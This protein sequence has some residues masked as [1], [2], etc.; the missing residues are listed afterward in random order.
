ML[1]LFSIIHAHLLRVIQA[2]SFRQTL[3]SQLPG[4][5]PVHEDRQNHGWQPELQ[6]S[7]HTFAPHFRVMS[8]DFVQDGARVFFL[9]Y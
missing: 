4:S 7:C 6:T 1:T 2:P 5:L 8:A 9:S 3:T